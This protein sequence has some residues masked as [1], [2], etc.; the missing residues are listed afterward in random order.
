MSHNHVIEPPQINVNCSGLEHAVP[1]VQWY[2]RT[3]ICYKAISNLFK[4]P[5][6]FV[7]EKK[8]WCQ[9]LLDKSIAHHT[10]VLIVMGSIRMLP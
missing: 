4:M 8:Q 6:N 3:Y 10:I 2:K 5:C 9:I 1:N 7:L